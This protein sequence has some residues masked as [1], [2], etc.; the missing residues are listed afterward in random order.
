MLSEEVVHTLRNKA[1]F[2]R[3]LAKF[4]DVKAVVPLEMVVSRAHRKSDAQRDAETLAQLQAKE[5]QR[6]ERRASLKT[7]Y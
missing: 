2:A 1:M 3:K 4:K 6:K 5:A 7:E